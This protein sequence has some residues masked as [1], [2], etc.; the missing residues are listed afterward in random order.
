MDTDVSF[1]RLTSRCLHGIHAVNKIDYIPRQ[2]TAVSN[3][4][5]PSLLTAKAS[6]N[7]S[8]INAASVHSP[9]NRTNNKYEIDVVAMAQTVPKNIFNCLQMPL[10]EIEINLPSG[11]DFAPS[12][13]SPD[14]FEPAIIPVTKI[15]FQIF[16]DDSIDG[17]Q[18]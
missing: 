17:M 5:P 4:P 7:L 8:C 13:K 14:L 1:Y 12:A 2:R 15:G 6:P 16:S 11:I 9:N 18:A 10:D 3:S